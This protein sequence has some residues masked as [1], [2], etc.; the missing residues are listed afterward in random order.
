MGV[1]VG[2][3]A[4]AI[5]QPGIGLSISSG[6]G[7][8]GGLSISRPLAVVSVGKAVVGVDMGVSVG[9]IRVG[10]G[11][12][13]VVAVSSP[14]SAVVQPGVSLGVGGG[15]SGGL[16]NGLGLSLLNSGHSGLLG[17]GGGGC[18]GDYAIS[19]GAGDKFAVVVGAAGGQGSVGQHV[20]VG[21]IGVGQHVPGGVE[22]G[23]VSLGLGGGLGAGSQGGHQQEPHVDA[24]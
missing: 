24:L 20:G 23:G 13:G 14:Q 2:V 17:G 11:P 3:I 15:L 4:I 7:I 18:H 6:L 5:S 1:S 8:S 10:E 22:E 16:G 9:G 19:V 12:V 21:P